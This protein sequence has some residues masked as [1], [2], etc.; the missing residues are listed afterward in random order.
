[1]NIK[2]IF[3]VLAAFA[4]F[5]AGI[6][7]VCAE[8]VD[9]HSLP[10]ET[11]YSNVALYKP[12]TTSDDFSLEM[13]AYPMFSLDKMVDGNINTCTLGT[14]P[15]NGWIQVDLQKRYNIEKIVLTD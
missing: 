1:M 8:D 12:V 13:Y 14:I 10:H 4:A 6:Y 15:Q 7:S 5:T 2:K 11:K 9:Y 3:S